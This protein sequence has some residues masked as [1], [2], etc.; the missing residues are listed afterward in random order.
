[1]S[2]SPLSVTE[3]LLKIHMK[4]N[5]RFNWEMCIN[6]TIREIRGNFS[7]IVSK[8]KKKLKSNSGLNFVTVCDI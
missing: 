6:K 1:M 3:F 5:I 2:Y 4:S 7:K 8:T